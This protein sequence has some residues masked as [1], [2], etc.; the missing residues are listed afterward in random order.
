MRGENAFTRSKSAIG[1]PAIVGEFDLCPLGISA[2]PQR[3]FDQQS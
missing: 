1:L 3:L 2:E